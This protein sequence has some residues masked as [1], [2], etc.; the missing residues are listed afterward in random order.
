MARANQEGGGGW[1]RGW[2]SSPGTLAA[3]LV[4]VMGSYAA[5]SLDVVRTGFGIKGD[6]ATYVSMTL[7]LAHDGDLVFDAGDLDRF[8]REY[9]AGPE[10]IFLKRGVRS[11]Y[12]FDEAFPFVKRVTRP[13]SSP[14]RAYYGKA[15]ISSVF[16]APFV[17]LAGLNGI[18]LFH[19]VLVAGMVWLGPGSW[20]R[21]RRRARRRSTPRCSSEPRSPRST[22]SG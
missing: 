22:G 8:F 2:V 1:I 9:Q 10:G 16:A 17:R 13:D 12:R 18:L 5:L 7:S 20:R 14:D 11:T 15:F 4:L 19:A 6:E 3:S 21:V